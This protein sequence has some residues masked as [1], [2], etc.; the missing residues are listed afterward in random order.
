MTRELRG[1]ALQFTGLKGSKGD[2]VYVLFLGFLNKSYKYFLCMSIDSRTLRI[3]FLLFFTV[4]DFGHVGRHA[5]VF[6]NQFLATDLEETNITCH[7][8]WVA[9]NTFAALRII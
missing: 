2:Y 6:S 4:L 5:I 3:M 8:S 9:E 7:A 1:L